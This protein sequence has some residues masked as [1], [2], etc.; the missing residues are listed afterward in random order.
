MFCDLFISCQNVTQ[1]IDFI[2]MK[3]EVSSRIPAI[4]VKIQK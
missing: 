4:P 2:L 1:K 3:F